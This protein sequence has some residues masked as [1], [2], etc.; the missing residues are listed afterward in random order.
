MCTQL[1][2]IHL[3]PIINHWIQIIDTENV[4]YEKKNITKPG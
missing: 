2:S 4:N 3:I 1:G